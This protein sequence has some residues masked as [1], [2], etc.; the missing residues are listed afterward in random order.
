[1]R[2]SSDIK[3]VPR[4]KLNPNVENVAKGI[5]DQIQ[6]SISDDYYKLI[7]GNWNNSNS[8]F[9]M[10]KLLQA[11]AEMEKLLNASFGGL[12][13]TKLKKGDVIQDVKGKKHEIVDVGATANSA[14]NP[15]NGMSDWKV[16]N[17]EDGNYNWLS[18]ALVKAHKMAGPENESAPPILESHLYFKGEHGGVDSDKVY[19]ASLVKTDKGY[20]VPF[21]Y[22]KNGGTLFHGLKVGNVPYEEAES[23][24]S[25]LVKSKTSKGYKHM[26]DSPKYNPKGEGIIGHKADAIITDETYGVSHTIPKIGFAYKDENGNQWK[27]TGFNDHVVN[28][29]SPSGTKASM[30]LDMFKSFTSLD[31]GKG[32]PCGDSF[33]SSDKTCHVGEP[34][35]VKKPEAPKHILAIDPEGTAY[36]VGAIYEHKNGDLFKVQGLNSDGTINVVSMQTGKHF[37][38][39]NSDTLT[40]VVLKMPP[41]SLNQTN[42]KAGDLFSTTSGT[43]QIM[44]VVH[45]GTIG[46]TLHPF[47]T[48]S[49]QA[50]WKYS[51]IEKQLKS[52]NPDKTVSI[53][54]SA[55]TAI[56][57]KTSVIDTSSWPTH[58]S[59]AMWGI[60]KI[61]MMEKLAED[62]QVGKLKALDVVPK[63]VSPNKYQK[64][65]HEAWK[66]LVVVAGDVASNVLGAT[67]KTPNYKEEAEQAVKE[68][69]KDAVDKIE[70]VKKVNPL[71]TF[72]K[73]GD[74]IDATAWK[75]IG[76]QKG[77]NPGGQYV[78]EDGQKWYLKQSK[79]NSHALNEVL[80]NKLYQAVD[81]PVLDSTLVYLGKNPDGSA[82]LGTASKWAETYGNID[83]NKKYDLQAAQKEFAVH[84]W[85]ANWDCVG[86]V[87]DNLS[88]VKKPYGAT[89]TCLDVGGSL[90]YRAT[91]ALKATFGESVNEWDT[92]RDPK[93]NPQSA[94]VFGSMTAQQLYDS[95]KKVVGGISNETIQD[96]VDKY[97]KWGGYSELASTI[98]KRRDDIEKRVMA[99][100]GVAKEV[101]N[102]HELS[103]QSDVA[104]SNVAAVEPAKPSDIPAPPPAL[105][106]QIP[107]KAKKL[108]DV[109]KSGDLNSL[110]AVEVF[111]PTA[112]KYKEE[113]IAALENK[114]TPIVAIP[115]PSLQVAGAY[116]TVQE[117]IYKAAIKGDKASIQS[118]VNTG[119]NVQSTQA[120]LEKVAE[121][122][123]IKKKGAEPKNGDLPKPDPYSN[124]QVKIH[125]LV[126]SGEVQ[127]ALTVAT[128]YQGSE[129]VG[130]ATKLFEAAGVKFEH[131]YNKPASDPGQPSAPVAPV[132]PA[133]PKITSQANLGMQKKFDLIYAAAL[134]GDIEKVKAIPTSATAKNTYSKSQHAYKMD[135]LTAM[136][137]G[138]QA[139][140]TELATPII[141]GIP[142]AAKQSKGA[143]AL[144][145]SELPKMD[146]VGGDFVS[147]N[148]ANVSQN[149][150]NIAELQK[151]A[152]AGDLASIES[153]PMF[154]SPKVQAYKN[155]LIEKMT[156]PPPP[157]KPYQGSI[158]EL[159][160]HAPVKKLNEVDKK[161]DY[162]LVVGNPGPIAHEYGKG[163]WYSHNDYPLLKKND[164]NHDNLLTSAEKAAFSEYKGSSSSINQSLGKGAPTKAAIAAGKG[165]MKA[166]VIVPEGMN[167]WRLFTVDQATLLELKNA[168][169]KAVQQPSVVGTSIRK[170]WDQHWHG[171]VKMK[172]T[173]GP[174]VKGLYLGNKHGCQSERE[175]LFPPNT[176]FVIQKAEMSGG[177]LSLE[178]F[179]LPTVETQCC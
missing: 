51:D 53:F 129:N 29:E 40:D 154:P 135:V 76:P 146:E 64:G 173:A 140:P 144:K 126:L 7:T 175:M 82:K 84:A 119:F 93:V 130:Y 68:N 5:A 87:N 45:T 58:N 36:Q 19:H 72:A 86:L 88:Y 133:P 110:K 116:L 44:K 105:M 108:Y 62:G 23:A 174:G 143:K 67:T 113:L 55:G 132:L 85:L 69:V 118:W 137:G 115:V 47:D 159:H 70:A 42:V 59:S 14:I 114:P 17:L 24:Y 16:K 34:Q 78:D 121:A 54:T 8:V 99:M 179:L 9:S 97:S 26:P 6:K 43:G 102:S 147:K 15:E 39:V 152:L 148:A 107:L 136:G 167:F 4:D 128:A 170:D 11:K 176:R 112:K 31:D 49:D 122:M 169:G 164:Q 103:A 38:N 101:D 158:D 160:K 162:L 134:T 95:A 127:K 12:D 89:M 165:I 166:G 155:L 33:I 83:P 57:P 168:T 100:Q 124:A 131:P 91:G 74:V 92:L 151:M 28:V 22:G 80:A 156:P 35:P 75:Q 20:T 125:S 139:A 46:A 138:V 90:F 41:T 161:F 117:N 32:K 21:A 111:N 172:L 3:P 63:S 65:V 66:K 10:E 109:A 81:S 178:V 37:S 79:S 13:I 157:P 141:T 120:Y 106:S 123:G 153:T 61:A 18:P 2:K 98:A 94:A 171:N 52:F 48:P 163:I 77:T 150:A 1:V 73:N 30:T 25:S 60:K 56:V 104:Q 145:Q 177:K 96:L 71:L 27:V 142:G 50:F 149:K